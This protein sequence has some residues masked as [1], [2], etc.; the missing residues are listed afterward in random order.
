[1]GRDCNG[2]GTHEASL[3]C[4]KNYRIAKKANCYSVRV[5]DCDGEAPLEIVITGLIS[6][7]EYITCKNL[8]RPSII[9]ILLSSC[10]S[11]SFNYVSLFPWEFQLLQLL[12]IAETM[13]VIIVQLVY[14]ELLQLLG[15]L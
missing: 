11:F 6:A 12:A 5:L 15:L 4:D 13:H 7:A 2:H 14:Q 8:C 1:M 9:S 3:A 10:Y